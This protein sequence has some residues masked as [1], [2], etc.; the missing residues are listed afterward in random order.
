MA[1]R[2]VFLLY[3]CTEFKLHTKTYL[4]YK[5]LNLQLTKTYEFKMQ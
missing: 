4:K 3:L 1:Y 2:F 5:Y